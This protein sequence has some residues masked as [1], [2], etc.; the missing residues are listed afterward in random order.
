MDLDKKSVSPV[1]SVKSNKSDARLKSGKPDE[2]RQSTDRS[3]DEIIA[4]LKD[5]NRNN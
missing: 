1:K 2:V 5:P 4:S 3:V